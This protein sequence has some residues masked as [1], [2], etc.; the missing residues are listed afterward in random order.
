VSAPTRF[1]AAPSGGTGLLS[2]GLHGLLPAARGLP[3]LGVALVLAMALTAAC[4]SSKPPRPPSPST[5][6]ANPYPVGVT[7]YPAASRV[8]LPALSGTTL[9][10]R[11][12]AV[13]DLRGHVVILNVWASWCEPCKSE[14]PALVAVAKSTKALGV[15]FIGI[16]EADQA[17]AA[18][19]FLQAIASPYPHLVDKDGRLFGQLARWLPQAV[20]G[21]LVLDPQG[22]VAARVIGPVTGPQIRAQI[23]AAAAQPSTADAQP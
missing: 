20:P 19:K 14:S 17:P 6:V 4:T 2:G 11:T 12:M 5:S 9:D 18:I 23:A 3:A 21:T 8:P 16:D 1:R 7:A 10:G 15:R 22:R 13:A